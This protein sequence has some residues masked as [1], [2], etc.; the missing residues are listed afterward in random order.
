[1]KLLCLS[2]DLWRQRTELSTEDTSL[3]TETTESQETPLYMSPVHDRRSECC[4][5][6]TQSPH[7]VP[8]SASKFKFF[9]DRNVQ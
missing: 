1:L 6:P 5:I 9:N 4:L 2:P 3:T 8:L 7:S